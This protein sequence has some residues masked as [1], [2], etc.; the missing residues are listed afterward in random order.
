MKHGIGPKSAVE[1]DSLHCKPTL[2]FV[3]ITKTFI[4]DSS[5][6]FVRDPNTTFRDP[7][8]GR[9]PQFEKPWSTA[10]FCTTF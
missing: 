8:W 7:I 10:C 2:T 4:C 5:S 6:E 1:I 9:D 3:K